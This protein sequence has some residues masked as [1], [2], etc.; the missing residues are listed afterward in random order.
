[1]CHLDTV[2]KLTYLHELLYLDDGIELPN[3]EYFKIDL[4]ILICRGEINI[5]QIHFPGDERQGNN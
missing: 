5:N 3:I 2:F 4:M 1:M